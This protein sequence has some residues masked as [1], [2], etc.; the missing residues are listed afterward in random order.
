MLLSRWLTSK[1]IHANTAK[2]GKTA[3]QLLEQKEF[4]VVVS[5]IMMPEMSGID[6]LTTVRTFSATQRLSW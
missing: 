5:D 1:G 6:L 3:V 2:N 4:D